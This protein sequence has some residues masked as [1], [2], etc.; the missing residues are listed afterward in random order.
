MI[1]WGRMMMDNDNLNGNKLRVLSFLTIFLLTLLACVSIQAAD[2]GKYSRLVLEKYNAR[3]VLIINGDDL[4]MNEWVNEAIVKGFDSGYLTSTSFMV[5][6]PYANEAMGIIR[7]RPDMD[8]G[9][10]LVLGSDE[11]NYGTR[12][13]PLAPPQAVVSLLD[14]DG[15]FFDGIP[16]PARMKKKD[17][18]AELTAQLDRAFALG[19]DVTH[20]DCHRGF[21]HSYDPNMLSV[22]FSL[23]RKYRLPIRWVG[24]PA[25]PMP[26]SKGIAVPDRFFAIDIPGPFEE[27]K[28]KLLTIISTMPDGV[29]ELLLHPGAGAPGDSDRLNR[30]TH[31][32]LLLDKDVQAAIMDNGIKL[33]GYRALR[34]AMRGE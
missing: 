22:V 3:K 27:K 29:S 32:D 2:V 24:K 6:F 34:D 7:T 28:A 26:A 14:S 23:A 12:V 19:V 11:G 9:V 18:E 17:V 21:Y 13:R 8:V 1:F 16:N 33:L 31:L 30:Q 25:D 5:S 20:F 4:G 15:A 10:H